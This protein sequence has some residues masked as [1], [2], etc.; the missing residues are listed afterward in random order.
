MI[1]LGRRAASNPAANAEIPEK[2]FI[3]M[4]CVMYIIYSLTALLAG[5]PMGIF[6][7]L[8]AGLLYYASSEGSHRYIT[9][10]ILMT[11]FPMF[12]TIDRLGRQ[13]Q[14]GLPLFSGPFAPANVVMLI[15]LVV[16]LVGTR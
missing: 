15:G 3:S 1:P 10:F 14:F 5:L 2:A 13:L 9:Y 11:C 6:D 7:I 16:Y 12:M 8:I 4:Y